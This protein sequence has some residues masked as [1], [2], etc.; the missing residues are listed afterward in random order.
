MLMR[1]WDDQTSDYFQQAMSQ[2]EVERLSERVRRR[3][4]VSD[5]YEPDGVANKTV[6]KERLVA[7]YQIK[8][9]PRAQVHVRM[10]DSDMGVPQYFLLQARRAAPPK[11]TCFEP[12]IYAPVAPAR[13]QGNG[14]NLRFTDSRILREFMRKYPRNDKE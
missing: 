8:D 4:S 14:A 9:L 6:V 7:D 2:V 1:V 13:S 3:S 5:E 10:A 12:R 11:P